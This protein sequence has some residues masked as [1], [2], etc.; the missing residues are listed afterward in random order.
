MLIRLHQHNFHQSTSHV[1]ELLNSESVTATA[2]PKE[3]NPVPLG[4]HKDST[5]VTK[6]RRTI[7]ARGLDLPKAGSWQFNPDS[8]SFTREPHQDEK[9]ENS[10]SG[11]FFNRNADDYEVSKKD[12]DSFSEMEY[13]PDSLHDDE[14]SFS[15]DTCYEK[16]STIT[17]TEKS[18]F[19]KIFKDIY[20]RKQLSATISRFGESFA[21]RV[22]E[23]VNRKDR[24]QANEKL[25]QII[26]E[27]NHAPVES[28]EELYKKIEQYPAAI[29]DSA[30]EAFGLGNLITD[31]ETSVEDL[32]LRAVNSYDRTINLNG[33]SPFGN[34]TNSVEL[35]RKIEREERL[36]ALR[37]TER[38]RV[39]ALMRACSTDFELWR[40]LQDEVFSLIPKL[41]LE[42][43]PKPVE[44]IPTIGKKYKRK[45]R[46]SPVLNMKKAQM[47]VKE[48]SLDTLATKHNVS[49]L[50]LYGPLYPSYLLLGLRLLDKSFSRPSHL[51]LALL[52]K[53]KS[54]GYISR[55]L[56][57]NTQFY[58]ELLLIY[59]F[60][61]NDF[62]GMLSL[63][64]EMELSSLLMNQ[65]TLDIIVQLSKLQ[66][67]VRS[68]TQ[69]TGMSTL[70]A[71]PNFARGKFGPWRDH[72]REKLG[73]QQKKFGMSRLE[74]APLVRT[75]I[76]DL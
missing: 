7:T 70:W 30:A 35:K 75:R 33:S 3:E 24:K 15:Y 66:D 5:N 43:V 45:Q 71:L 58:N 21:P 4:D 65:D 57:A 8:L 23:Q 76:A 11:T 16:R 60:R 51:A 72:L 27:S 44:L 39:E 18:A 32:H 67:R 47:Q 40:V 62:L 28:M 22:E 1:K 13:K 12:I 10:T 37:E 38:E 50:E 69:G 41:G 25:T 19:Q 2:G 61:Q 73:A 49:P 53:I 20:E 48:Q 68:G 52:P 63:L 42:D 29:R 74:P 17:P 26:S 46:Y 59:R 14:D 34:L 64:E 9:P 36:E 31:Q 6:V 54:L 55:V 56:G